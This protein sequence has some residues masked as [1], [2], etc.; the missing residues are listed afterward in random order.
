MFVKIKNWASCIPEEVRKKDDFMP[1]DAFER[2]VYPGKV[3]SPFVGGAV[4]GPGGIGEPLDKGE[5]KTEGRKRTRR[6]AAA[7]E[8]ASAAVPKTP[9]AQPVVKAHAATPTAAGTGDTKDRTMLTAAGT[10][11]VPPIVD[12]LPPETSGFR[13][14]FCL[15]PYVDALDSG[16]FR[17]GARDERGTVVCGAT[18]A[19]CAC[20]TCQA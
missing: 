3:T 9:A 1:I 20:A 16:V 7:A 15:G 19:C 18:D 8:G 14:S 12:K 13:F 17:S 5:D 2:L 11:T 6:Q 10:L 4:K